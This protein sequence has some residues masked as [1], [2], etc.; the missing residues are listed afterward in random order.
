[1]G[2]NRR[3]SG[4]KRKKATS[5]RKRKLAA[6]REATAAK[7]NAPATAG[8]DISHGKK[9]RNA[10]LF[11]VA[12]I[13]LMLAVAVLCAVF[14]LTPTQ[15]VEVGGRVDL[16]R[17]DSGIASVI[18]TEHQSADEIDTSKISDERLECIFFGFIR[19][20]MKIQVRD[21]ISPVLSVVDV[22]AGIGDEV[23]I[24]DFILSCEDKTTVKMEAVGGMPSALTEGEYRVDIL[25]TDEGGNTSSAAASLTV[26]GERTVTHIEYGTDA[27]EA[28]RICSDNFGVKVEA[29]LIDVSRCGE[30]RIKA[31]DGGAVYIFSVDVSDTTPPVATVSSCDIA[32]GSQL[33][34]NKIVSDIEDES[35]VTV[36]FAEPPELA[37]TGDYETQ[38]VLRDEWGN[39]TRYDISVR[40]HDIITELTIE[41]G[42][43][44]D[45]IRQM[46]LGENELLTIDDE[47]F[48]DI[49]TLGE[50]EID[51]V[52][53]Y[54]TVPVMITVEDTTPPHLV[55][56]ESVGF[57][58]QDI[59]PDKLVSECTDATKVTLSFDEDVQTDKPGKFTVTVI[60]EDEAGNRTEEKTNLLITID[61]EPP[62]IYGTSTFYSN[63]GESGNISF[64]EG[65]YAVDNA[66]GIVN[67]ITDASAVD[68]TTAGTY[69]VRYSATDKAGNRAEISASVIVNPITRETVDALADNVLSY[70]ISDDM[71]DYDKAWAIYSW[72]KTNITYSARTGN[73]I[74]R[75]IDG[76]YHGFKSRSGNCYVYYSVAATMLTRAGIENMEVHRVSETNPHYWNLVNIG[77]EWYHFDTCPHYSQYPLESFLLTDA[78]VRE[79]SEKCVGYY[80]FD[81]SLYPP[82]P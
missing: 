75:F 71:T 17:L 70:I 40:V 60:A 36:S 18:C 9:V 72:C 34:L 20:N 7:K 81:S 43:S 59:T 23:H 8:K 13:V 48:G 14:A 10:V 6:Q 27:D 42:S 3:T 47:A 73:L 15:T 67:V 63:V 35:E 38:V 49:S 5:A 50:H 46:I 16:S 78:E 4:A 32:L 76:A 64:S 66:D 57:I 56:R 11:S 28:A 31:E 2:K 68:L 25:V 51:A 30:Q 39:E 58:G 82:T 37:E 12:A 65:V 33:D 55:L 79:Y 19:K 61:T 24:G 54:S 29:G 41:A 69:Y 26:R 80:D 52:G 62:V 45:E 53:E 21:T 22:V 1:M 74:G 77:G 44:L